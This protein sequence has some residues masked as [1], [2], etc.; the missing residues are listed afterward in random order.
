[1]IKRILAIIRFVYNFVHSKLNPIGYA[2]SIGVKMGTNVHF[3]GMKPNMFSTEPWLITIGNNVFITADCAF[4]THDGGTLILRKEVPDLE[5]TAPIRVGNDVYMG[6]RT[7]IMPGVTIGN[8]VIIAA[9]SIV[10]KDIPDNSVVAGVPAR[11][12]KSVD[13]YLLKAQANSLHLGNLQGEDKAKE[14]KKIFG[15]K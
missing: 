1:M 7:I 13:D 6:I 2:K 8:R 3:Y 14:L 5:L 9:G 11:V 15:V 10:T 12:I 4:I